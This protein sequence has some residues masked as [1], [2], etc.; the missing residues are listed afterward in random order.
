MICYLFF[1]VKFTLYQL[2]R[3]LLLLFFVRMGDRNFWVPETHIYLWRDERQWQVYSLEIR[4]FLYL[5][6]LYYVCTYTYV[7]VCVSQNSMVC[8]RILTSTTK[9]MSNHHDFFISSQKSMIISK[10][11]SLSSDIVKHNQTDLFP[12]SELALSI[13]NGWLSC[14]SVFLRWCGNC[15]A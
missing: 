14:F 2:S 1:S 3:L 7:Y 10:K 11:D 9:P 13:L 12:E 4:K 6:V 5:R 15:K 8:R